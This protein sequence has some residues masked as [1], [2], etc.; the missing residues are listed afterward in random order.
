[1]V[2]THIRP[3]RSAFA[4]AASLRASRRTRPCRTSG[5]SNCSRRKASISLAAPWRSTA[6][7]CAFPPRCSAAAKTYLIRAEI[8]LHVGGGIVINGHASTSDHYLAF[9]AAAERLAKQL[10]RYK[11]R[12]RDH[13]GKAHMPAERAEMARS[14]VLAPVDEEDGIDD[15]ST[16]NGTSPVVIAEMSTEL[17]QLTVG[18]AVMRMDLADAPVLLF[19][20]RSH[21]VR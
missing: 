3:R 20:N 16:A 10:R 5:S 11:R 9:D 19:A 17:P 15:G 8:S 18:E 1:M 6:R 13:H 2:A 21:G 7:Q 4:S 14:F 12:L